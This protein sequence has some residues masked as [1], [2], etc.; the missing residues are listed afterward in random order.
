MKLL[1]HQHVYICSFTRHLFQI[2]NCLPYSVICFMKDLVMIF[3]LKSRSVFEWLVPFLFF[4]PVFLYL[5]ARH[6]NLS[7]YFNC[8]KTQLVFFVQYFNLL[9]WRDQRIEL[10][11]R[12]RF[13]WWILSRQINV[14]LN[15]DVVQWLFF[16]WSCCNLRWVDSRSLT[17]F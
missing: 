1:L 3:L 7:V 11:P 16:I 4:N 9:R 12:W 15:Y 17:W 13:L 14:R 5:S 10:A 8:W 2:I 6:Y